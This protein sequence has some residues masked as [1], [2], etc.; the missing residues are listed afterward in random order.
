MVPVTA[1]AQVSQWDVYTKLS[2]HIVK[3]VQ[4]DG[5]SNSNKQSRNKQIHLKTVDSVNI[6]TNTSLIQYLKKKMAI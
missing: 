1:S 3:L 6:T 4:I 2:C 5:D